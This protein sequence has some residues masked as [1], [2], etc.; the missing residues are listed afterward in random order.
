MHLH[1]RKAENQRCQTSTHRLYY[2]GLLPR[3][4]GS[5]RDRR[6]SEQEEAWKRFPQP[7]TELLLSERRRRPSVV[8]R[9][10][11]PHHSLPISVHRITYVSR[12]VSRT[13]PIPS[14]MLSHRGCV[15]CLLCLPAVSARASTDRS[16]STTLVRRNTRALRRC[17]QKGF[18]AFSVATTAPTSSSSPCPPPP[19]PKCPDA[20][21]KPVS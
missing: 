21:L 16:R 19:L 5:E 6:E 18:H 12:P 2:F 7:L 14:R 3:R 20:F 8:V 15:T 17:R 10:R 1:R 4:I 11:H 13:F 9:G